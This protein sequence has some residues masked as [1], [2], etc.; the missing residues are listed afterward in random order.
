MTVVFSAANGQSEGN[1]SAWVQQ[2]QLVLE[3]DQQEFGD[4]FSVLFTSQGDYDYYVVDLTKL[5]GRF[6]RIY[7]LNL[8]YSESKIVN[9][10]SDIE[11]GQTWFKAY[12]NYTNEEITCL[13][14]EL[15]EKT[16]EASQNM[17]VEE[18]STWMIKFDKFKKSAENE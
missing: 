5:G 10:D 9:L 6:E 14:E 3:F 15:K 4:R 2:S 8:T 13:F 11:K 1:T 18:K 12:Y 16:T 17:T 7:F